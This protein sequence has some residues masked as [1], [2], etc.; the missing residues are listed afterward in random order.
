LNPDPENTFE[1]FRKL[2]DGSMQL[3]DCVKDKGCA[4]T[5]LGRQIGSTDSRY[6]LIWSPSICVIGKETLRADRLPFACEPDARGIQPVLFE[7][8]I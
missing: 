8:L 6:R 2:S 1:R 4:V 5:Q 7:N 3:V